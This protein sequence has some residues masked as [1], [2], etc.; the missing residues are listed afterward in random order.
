M[1]SQNKVGHVSNL[2]TFPAKFR[3]C[4]QYFCFVCKLS[5]N[6]EPHDELEDEV[7]LLEAIADVA[8]EK[9]DEMIDHVEKNSV[10]EADTLK[11]EEL[12]E[13]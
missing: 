6:A 7:D 1:P 9:N 13:T 4:Y 12:I 8:M 5:K 2:F 3:S 11:K 10:V